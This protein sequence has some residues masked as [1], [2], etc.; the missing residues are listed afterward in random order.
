VQ[1]NRVSMAAVRIGD[2]L[3]PRLPKVV[4]RPEIDPEY[5]AAMSLHVVQR[6]EEA[7]K[8]SPPAAA[9]YA[10]ASVLFA[11][12]LPDQSRPAEQATPSHTVALRPRRLPSVSAARSESHPHRGTINKLAM[13]G[14]DVHKLAFGIPTPR[15]RTR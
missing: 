13:K 10:I 11:V 14:A 1:P 7:A 9:S 8:L 15:T 3:P 12:W 5:F 2:N 6:T 4:I